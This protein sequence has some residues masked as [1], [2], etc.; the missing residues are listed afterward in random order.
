MAR[1]TRS[2]GV[3]E[4]LT[5]EARDTWSR[6]A[7]QRRADDVVVRPRVVIQPRRAWTLGLRD[8]WRYRQ[9][10]Y[11]FTLRDVKVRYKQTFFGAAW[12]VI[13]PLILLGVFGVFFG[14]L[15][16]LPSNG[17][18][19]AV[20]ALAALVPWTLFGNSF[21]SAAQSVVRNTSLVSKVYFPR[22]AIPISAGGSFLLDFVLATAVLVVLQSFYGITPTLRFFAVPL[23]GAFALLAALSLGIWFAALNVRYRDVAYVVPFITQALM[24]ASPI[25]YPSTLIPEP[26]R[27]LYGLNPIAGVIESFRWAASGA[28]TLPLGMLAVS[29]GTS[30]VLFATGLVYFQR[31]ERTF[32]DVI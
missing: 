25:G 27:V 11:F 1:V 23:L 8:L 22:L 16:G 32:A 6:E 15:A 13:Q 7:V 21:A 28:H 18:P 17:L 12:A 9:L 10:L 30:L 19:Y 26:W 20:F 4:D 14:R 31:T 24:F 29:V 2:W 3:I 5:S